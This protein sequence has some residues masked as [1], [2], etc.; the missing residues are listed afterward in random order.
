[1][2]LPS[3]PFLGPPAAPLVRLGL[4]PGYSPGD[5]TPHRN[6]LFQALSW[7][8]FAHASSPSPVLLLNPAIQARGRRWGWE[9]KFA[10]LIEARGRDTVNGPKTW[11]KLV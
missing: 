1:M 11:Q 6:S 9:N 4:N 3:E 8:S 2:V 10:C 7:G 5:L